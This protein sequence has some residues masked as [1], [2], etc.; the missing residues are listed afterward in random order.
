MYVLLR[1]IEA[2]S[3]LLTSP[4]MGQKDILLGHFFL[5]ILNVHYLQYSTVQFSDIQVIRIEMKRMISL[6]RVQGSSPTFLLA[7][8]PVSINPIKPLSMAI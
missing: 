8:C 6:G 4:S 1:S 3:K 5:V 7:L 2:N